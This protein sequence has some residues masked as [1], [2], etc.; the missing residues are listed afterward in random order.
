VPTARRAP[1]FDGAVI[2]TVG[3]STRAIEDFILLLR[4]HDVA[5]VADVRRFPGSRRYPQFNKESLSRALGD[6]GIAYEHIES[7]GGRRAAHPVSANG[8]LRNPQFRSYADHMNTDEFDAALT[9]LVDLSRS[10]VVAVMCAEA[11][12]WRCHRSLLADALLAR[13]IDVVHI[14]DEKDARP[15]SPTQG[16]VFA[17]GAVTYPGAPEGEQLTLSEEPPEGSGTR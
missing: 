4:A 12:P 15:H 6:A 13:G 2:L 17:D 5:L 8:G 14:V 11:V 16:A 3:H 7:L 9:H 1:C 10:S